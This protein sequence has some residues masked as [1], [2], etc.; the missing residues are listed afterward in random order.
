[1]HSP[2]EVLARFLLLAPERVLSSIE[3]AC[4][5]RGELCGVVLETQT[6]T[7]GARKMA[8]AKMCAKSPHSDA[9]GRLHD[10]E[11]TSAQN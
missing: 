2:F 4:Q 5:Q 6:A 7:P 3:D 1:L 9:C 10:L 11:A 8:L